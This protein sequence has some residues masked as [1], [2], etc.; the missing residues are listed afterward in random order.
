MNFKHLSG[1]LA[2]WLEELSRF[3]FIIVHKPGKAHGAADALSRFPA[4][5]KE[6]CPF[7]S[8]HVPLSELPCKG[9]EKCVAME[10][11]WGRF[12]DLYDDV[13]KL[14]KRNQACPDYAPELDV[15]VKWVEMEEPSVCTVSIFD[16]SEVW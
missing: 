9:C 2:R 1:Q 11:Q 15:E 4:H 6:D 16:E 7:Y 14:S 8:R 12:L 5:M 13:Q 3:R 10:K